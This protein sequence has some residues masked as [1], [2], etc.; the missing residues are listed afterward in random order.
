MAFRDL[1]EEESWRVRILFGCMLAGFAVLLI[2]LWHMQVTRG[3][4]YQ[5]DLMQQSVRRVRTPGIRGRIFDRNGTCLADNRPSYCI[6]MY[7]EEMRQTGRWTN[8]I[9][10]V[11]AAINNLSRVLGRPRQITLDDIQTHIKKRLPLPLLAWRDL[12]DS[13]LARFSE[14]AANLPGVDIYTEAVRKYPL[15]LTACHA[16][17]Y[18]GRADVEQDEEEPYHYYL[19]DMIGKSGI[20]KSCDAFLRGEPGGRI[21]LVDVSGFWHTNLAVRESTRGSDVFLTLETNAQSQAEKALTDLS[22]AVVIVDP[23]NGDVLAMA[24]SPGFDPNEFTVSISSERWKS[25]ITDASN[26]LVNRAIAGAYAPGSTFKPVI[27][28]A[29]LQSGAAN[30]NT[31]FTCPGYFNLGKAVFHCWY[32]SG[33]GL[34]NLQQGIQHSCNV[35]FFHLGLKTGYDSIYHMAAALGFGRKTEVDL[36]YEVPGLLPDNAWKQRAL[37]DKWRDGDTCNLSIGQGALGVTPLQMAM[38]VATLAN[39]GQ[40]FKPRIVLGIRRPDEKEMRESPTRLVNDLNWAPSTIRLVRDGMRDVVMA[41]GGTGKLAYVPGLEFAGKTGTAEY[42]K[43]GEGHKLA[44]MIAFAPFD[45]PRY[46]VVVMV[47][48]G[49]TGGQ[50]AAP[51]MKQIMTGLFQDELS[52]EGQG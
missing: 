47:E 14:N 12:D 26:P 18:V 37:H 28:L 42:G 19:P 49:V 35:Y 52:G 43:K 38:Y 8:T 27:A 20:E 25:L 36:D 23:R 29:A 11:D 33:H 40:L 34:L 2:V 22:G 10:H 6:A 31:S 46:A 15:G 17:G 16:I 7:L 4:S 50:T 24:S 32:N 39:G 45:H 1:F 51:R 21:I 30:A 13:A 5:H 44:W 48:E 3:K 41:P 9:S